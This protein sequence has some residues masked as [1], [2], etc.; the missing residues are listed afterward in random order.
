MNE[1]NLRIQLTWDAMEGLVVQT[2]Y[3]FYFRHGGN[4][5]DILDE[6]QEAGFQACL[7]LRQDSQ[8]PQVWMRRKVWWRLQDARRRE[9][10]RYKRRVALTESIPQRHRFN[11]D[12][13]DGLS[14][15]ALEVASIVTEP[16]L[17]VRL[18]L[19]DTNENGPRAHVKAI[20]TYL[21][22]RGWRPSRIRKAMEELRESLV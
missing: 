21:R 20:R 7:S 5:E 22:D 12:W 14:A 2:A 9:A 18:N 6:A 8:K 19:A 1:L 13:K 4:L 3:Q 17:D 11:I 15:D 16:P 10:R